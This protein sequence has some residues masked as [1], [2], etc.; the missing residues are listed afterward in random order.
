MS[1]KLQ[2]GNKYLIPKQIKE[3]GITPEIIEFSDPMVKKIIEEYTMESGVRNLERQI[4]T[5]CRTVAYQ[6]AIAEDTKSFRKVKVNEAIVEE[7]LGNPKFDVL[8]SERITRPGVAVG[9]AYTSYGG[10]ALLIETTMYPGSGQL[11][12][13][14]KLGEVMRESVNTC[15]SWIKAN[16][17][18]LGIIKEPSK[19]VQVSTE[20]QDPK[21]LAQM[22]FRKFDIHV[23]F[24]AAA[25]PKDGPSAG[26]T[27]ATSLVSLLTNRRV[28]KNVAMTGEISLQGLVLPIGG[29]KDKCIA[30][31]RNNMKTVILPYQNKK[32]SNEIPED[33]RGKLDIRFAKTIEQ[34]LDIALEKK[35]DQEFIKEQKKPLFEPK[36]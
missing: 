26:V 27:V 8:L 30:A 4:G 12:L 31:H 22:Y 23:H 19:A 5:V 34:I 7:A 15:L 36:L 6:Y 13:T 20:E 25:V 17:S 9:L 1:E 21:S 2:I 28:K 29:V 35:V 32:D 11:V 33:V 10:R 3:N 24:P 16:S 14:G 18:K